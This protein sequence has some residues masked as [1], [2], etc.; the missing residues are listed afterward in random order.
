[1]ISHQE[2]LD[3]IATEAAARPAY[4]LKPACSEVWAAWKCPLCGR[5]NDRKHEGLDACDHCKCEVATRYDSLGDSLSVKWYR[6]NTEISEP[7]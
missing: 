3:M 7:R 5:S 6:P 4:F 1:M 2:L